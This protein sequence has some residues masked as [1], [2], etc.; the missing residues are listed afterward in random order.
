MCGKEHYDRFHPPLVGWHS[1]SSPNF[2]AQESLTFKRDARRYEP[3]SLNLAGIIGLR[4]ALAVDSGMRI[5]G[6][7]GAGA[8]FGAAGDCERDQGGICGRWPD[9]GNG[10]IGDRIAV[11]RGAGNGEVA[12]RAER[13]ERSLHHSVTC[14]TGE[15]VCG[16][17]PIFTTGTKRWRGQSSGFDPV[18]NES[19]NPLGMRGKRV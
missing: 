8:R 17:R 6:R 15:S 5:G 10:A 7:G 9:G 14:E 1:A 12:R 2:I 16:C 11:I 4:A 13:G 18:G 3:G 19:R